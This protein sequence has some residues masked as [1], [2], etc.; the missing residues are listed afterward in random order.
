MSQ[1]LE[2][3]QS[4]KAEKKEN[5]QWT[6]TPSEF[7]MRN[8]ECGKNQKPVLIENDSL[9]SNQHLPNKENQQWNQQEL[10]KLLDIKPIVNSEDESQTA[11]KNILIP[12]SEFRIQMKDRTKTK[13][14]FLGVKTVL[15]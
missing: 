10:A 5:Q 11:E 7:G 6:Q 4:I 9:L 13:L 1:Q 8:A 12:N 15:L 14:L 3:K 2:T